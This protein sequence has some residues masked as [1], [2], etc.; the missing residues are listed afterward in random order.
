MNIKSLAFTEY[1]IFASASYPITPLLQGS[2]AG[3]Y[4]PDLKGAFAGPS[5]SYNMLE[6]LDLSFF[7]QYFSAELEHPITLEKQR[8]KITL[9]F[10]R[11][12]WS[13]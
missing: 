4:F 6:N 8:Q 5:L 1:S 9:A 7:F 12:K 11:L 10:L 3:M 13:F 2:L